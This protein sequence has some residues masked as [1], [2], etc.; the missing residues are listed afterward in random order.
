MPLTH[1]EVGVVVVVLGRV[2]DQALPAPP[3]ATQVRSAFSPARHALAP[4]HLLGPSNCRVV[5]GRGSLT[6]TWRSS[7]YRG[8]RCTGMIR[9]LIRSSLHKDKGA[10]QRPDKRTPEQGTCSAMGWLPGR[11]VRGVL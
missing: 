11:G 7:L 2:V 4:G 5:G 1:P 6:L 9:K 10:S 8:I 3:T